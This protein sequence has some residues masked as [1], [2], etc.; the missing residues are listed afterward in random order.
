MQSN[1]G[2]RFSTTAPMNAIAL[3]P[4]SPRNPEPAVNCERIAI[5]H[6]RH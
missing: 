6:V 1:R 2:M 4:Q 5:A 3:T